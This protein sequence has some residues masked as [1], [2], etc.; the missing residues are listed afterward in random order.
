MS[1][2]TMA[3][4]IISMLRKEHTLTFD[5]NERADQARRQ[6]R[7]A[8]AIDL[9]QQS[10]TLCS[11]ASIEAEYCRALA[12]MHLG[13]IHHSMGNLEQAEDC[14]RQ[15]AYIFTVNEHNDSQWNEAVALCALGLVAQ[16]AGDWD[17]AQRLYQQSLRHF[18]HLGEKGVDV[19]SSE[20]LV[21]GR[22]RHLDFLRQ[23]R[24][25]TRAGV[26]SVPI[27][28]ATAAGEPIVAIEVQPEY[29]LADRIRLRDR[30]CVIKR[31]LQE[32]KGTSVDLK[33]SSAYFALRVE[34]NSM[35]GVGIQDGDYVVFRQQSCA[36]SED[37]VVVR[38]DYPDE[39]RS[40]IKRFERRGNIILLKA[41]N[42][43]YQPQVQI[44]GI[45]DPTIETLGKAVAVVS[46]LP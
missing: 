31:I 37:I 22:M 46:V 23:Q 15:G 12:Q 17:Q 41:E 26:Y 14:Y 1:C 32:G 10:L 35:T 44:F 39:S 38:I 2:Q 21:M 25:E 5:F 28:G 30:T 20:H 34:G 24:R 40:T 9:C 27:I 7:W 16:S 3:D 19:S 29:V 11:E 33:P 43:D 8:T 18:Q 36:D 13:A 4:E 42:P 45:D 6:M